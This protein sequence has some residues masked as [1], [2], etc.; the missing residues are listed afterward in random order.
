MAVRDYANLVTCRAH[1]DGGSRDIAGVLFG[2]RE[3][4]VVQVGDY[5]IDAVPSGLMLVMVN[6]DVPGVIGTV[7]TM[8]GRFGVNIAE[9]RLGRSE[10]GR[11]ALSF[12]NL[13]TEPPEEAMDA[14]RSEEAITKLL[15]L[16]L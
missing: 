2:G 7:G 4:R 5:H 16:R 15:L 14:L 10:P 12:I 11:E 1:T 13:D 3:P 8:L 6:K 9:W